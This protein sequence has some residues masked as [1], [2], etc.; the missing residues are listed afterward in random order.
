MYYMNLKSNSEF[1]K[2]FE[3]IIHGDDDRMKGR[4]LKPAPDIYL[5]AAQEISIDPTECI[6]F[7]DSPV[8]VLS[9][10][11]AGMKV[12]A[13]PEKNADGSWIFPEEEFQSADVILE[14]LDQCIV[15]RAG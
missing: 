11:N 5:R 10:Y 13:I 4:S 14:R 7:E 2:N 1:F 9:A 3:T 6:A 12:I 8:G 15:E